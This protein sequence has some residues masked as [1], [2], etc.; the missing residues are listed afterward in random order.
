MKKLFLIPLALIFIIAVIAGCADSSHSGVDNASTTNRDAVIVPL[1]S[2]SVDEA[3]LETSSRMYYT[4]LSDVAKSNILMFFN[5]FATGIAPDGQKINSGSDG[6]FGTMENPHVAS[7][8][9]QLF[10]FYAKGV[11]MPG[12]PATPNNPFKAL[13]SYSSLIDSAVVAETISK[14]RAM[15]PAEY[16]KIE[17]MFS[18]I[19]KS[20][21]AIADIAK[22]YE[23][24]LLDSSS[25]ASKTSG[26]GG[27][28]L[29][30]EYQVS[31]NIAYVIALFPLFSNSA[32]IDANVDDVEMVSKT[33]YD[34]NE[35]SKL[36]LSYDK[37]LHYFN[38]YEIATNDEIEKIIVPV[39]R[40]ILEND[41]PG[42]TPPSEA[43]MTNPY[44]DN[45]TDYYLI[46]NITKRL[47][48]APD[49]KNISNAALNRTLELHKKLREYGMKLPKGKTSDVGMENVSST[50]VKY[51]R[52]NGIVYM[53]FNKD[54][55]TF[56]TNVIN[57]VFPT[58]TTGTTGQAGTTQP[59][60]IIGC[61][62]IAEVNKSIDDSAK[63]YAPNKG[64]YYTTVDKGKLCGITI[65]EDEITNPTTGA[66]T[67]GY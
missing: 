56:T 22:S 51:L 21:K 48:G 3:I 65:P 52:E 67:T 59:A 23:S 37:L 60:D 18:T 19:V 38:V 36:K 45:T 13:L 17:I 9:V 34:F 44:R 10:Y 58:D 26:G 53:N 39:V 63:S 12:L 57:K 41:I 32:A 20:Q 27:T 46:D 49:E 25:S 31:A 64:Y 43:L 8:V 54:V 42:G 66:S 16:E 28:V 5:T 40:D 33:L 14:I 4:E 47:Y 7:A 2:M 24:R 55:S 35:A 50:I 61:Q 11:S 62:I 29:V 30:D 1:D 15:P 6:G